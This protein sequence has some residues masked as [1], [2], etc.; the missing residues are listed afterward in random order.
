MGLELGRSRARIETQGG[1]AIKILVTGAAGGLAAAL[2]PALEKRRHAVVPTDI[3]RDASP[4]HVHHLDVRDFVEVNAVVQEHRPD[5]VMHLAAETDVDRC[6]LDPDHAFRTN[7]LGTENV[8]LMCQREQLPMVYIS[9]GG[10]FDGAKRGPYTEFDTPNPVNV[11]GCSKLAGERVVQTL[12]SRHY[13]FRAGWMIGSPKKDK[14][15][16]ATILK[17]LETQHELKAV[18]DKFG[19]PTFAHDISENI[20]RVVQEER[21]GL[22]HTVNRGMTTRYE[23]AQTIVAY[24]GRTDVKVWPVSSAHFPLVAPR[25][26]SEALV[27]YKLDLL[28]LNVMPDWQT[29]LR[30]YIGSRTEHGA[31]VDA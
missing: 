16:V 15:F 8:A 11:Y 22:Y 4:L 7:A 29:A 10:V 1:V 3:V 30:A 2:C 19:T 20:I 21:Y 23:L 31:R 9:T 6:E 27:N 17:L 13:I 28:G 25:A 26:T 18:D 5:L 24:V 14:K 12:L